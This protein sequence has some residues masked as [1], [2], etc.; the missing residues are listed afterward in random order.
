MQASARPTGGLAI[1]VDLP[2]APDVPRR[3]LPSGGT[4]ELSGRD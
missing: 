1:R 2:R 3:V 4:V